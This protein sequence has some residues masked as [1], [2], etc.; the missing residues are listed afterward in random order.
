MDE[1]RKTHWALSIKQPWAWAIIC[2]GKNIENRDWWADYR[3]ELYIH[4]SKRFDQWG[5][6]KLLKGGLIPAIWAPGDLYRGGIIG[7]VKLVDVVTHSKSK[8]FE[9]PYGFVLEDPEP[10]DFFPLRGRLNI[11]QFSFEKKEAP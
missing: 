1:S 3:G 8:W 5:L 9:G 4:A 10:I 6:R 7:K 2:A 11:F